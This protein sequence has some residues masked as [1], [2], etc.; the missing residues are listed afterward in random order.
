MFAFV[1]II[2]TL[3]HVFICT[4]YGWLISDNKIKETKMVYHS[5][6]IP[7]DIDYSLTGLLLCT[8]CIEASIQSKLSFPG[9]KPY[10]RFSITMRILVF[11]PLL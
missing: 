4:Y 9:T 3:L 10:F 6:E 8:V 2:R 11:L 5:D 7:L 1:C